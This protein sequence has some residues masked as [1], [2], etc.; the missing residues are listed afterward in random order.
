MSALTAR[1]RENLS[2][3]AR[4]S[5]EEALGIAG[6][7]KR[8]LAGIELT[9][10]LRETRGAFVTLRERGVVDATGHPRLRGCIG[11]IEAREALHESV[12]RNAAHA[13]LDDP[14]FAP[15]TRDELPGLSVEISALTPM[16]PVAGPGEIVCGRDGVLLERGSRRAVFLPQ[17]ATEQGW[18]VTELLEHLAQKAGLAGDDWRDA[19]LSVFE[20]EVFSATED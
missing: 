17:V 18:S 11:T 13:A 3:L 16:R 14:R 15:V 4:A 9:P 1:E 20:A 12:V 8:A 19:K 10:A 2:L 6:A 7:V 5:L